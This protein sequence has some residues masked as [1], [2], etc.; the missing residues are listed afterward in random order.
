MQWGGNVSFSICCSSG[1][2]WTSVDQILI[3]STP[4]VWGEFATLQHDEKEAMGQWIKIS[5]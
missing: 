3:K 1:L 5:K 4:T 2:G